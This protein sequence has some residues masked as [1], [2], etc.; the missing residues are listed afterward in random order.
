MEGSQIGSYQIERKLGAGGMGV[1]YIGID[2]RLGR[3]AAIK[4]L[5]PELSG[6]REIVERFFNE[7]KAAANINHPGIVEIYDVGWHSDGSAYFAMKWLDGDSLARRIRESGP[8][9][10]QLATT[11]ARQ[12][13]SALAAAH[14]AGIV[15]RDLKP[16]NIVLVRDDEVTIGERATVLDFGIAK[17]F[18]EQSASQ[19]TRTGSLL[20]TPAYMSPEQCRGA[21]EVDLRTDVYAL[22]CILFEML[23]GRPPHIGAGTGEVLGM[24]QF[25][26]ISKPSQFRKDLPRPLEALV[27]RALA[28]KP[29]ERFQHMTELMQALQPFA[30]Q[31]GRAPERPARP[32]EP[33]PRVVSPHAATQST[34]A[35]GHGEVAK[36]PSP[37]RKSRGL[38]LGLGGALVLGTVITIAAV[39]SSS[40]KSAKQDI[41]APPADAAVAIAFDAAPVPAP[42]PESSKL[43]AMLD[44]ATAVLNQRQW[45]KAAALAG[46]ALTI[47]PASARAK[48]ILT[49]ANRELVAESMFEAFARAA[50]ANDL[51]TLADRYAAIDDTSVYKA[52][53]KPTY[54]AAMDRYLKVARTKA[55][56]LAKT[57][58][59]GELA[60]FVIQAAKLF[61]ETEAPLAAIKCKGATG[62]GLVDPIGKSE[63]ELFIDGDVS[64]QTVRR[65]TRPLRGC[66][67]CLSEEPADDLARGDV[68]LSRTVAGD[69]GTAVLQSPRS[70]RP[71]TDAEVLQV[72]G[73]RSRAARGVERSERDREAAL[74]RRHTELAQARRLGRCLVEQ[75]DRIAVVRAHLGLDHRDR[76]SR[77]DGLLVL[78]RD[79]EPR[80]PR[81]D[82][83]TQVLDVPRPQLR[84]QRD[85]RRPVVDRVDL[86][87]QRARRREH[88]TGE[89]RDRAGAIF[90]EP[91]TRRHHGRH[92]MLGEERANRVFHQLDPDDV[93]T[94]TGE[95]REVLGLA[96]QRDQHAAG[97]PRCVTGQKLVGCAFVKSDAAFA[98]ALF[99]E[100]TFHVVKLP[101]SRPR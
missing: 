23:T 70:R 15:H 100:R 33:P 18:G 63:D 56:M 77:H 88:V 49:Q 101:R 38:W 68:R 95:K 29:E 86:A 97:K 61:P 46:D 94:A 99:P 74:G 80:A 98:P 5:L 93:V 6:N 40:G 64:E 75:H 78:D 19:K 83:R 84:R 43:A 73:H 11:I 42:P 25:V 47:D 9:P 8:M 51:P 48:E 22:G 17:L 36:P 66:A 67:A 69:E 87:D 32:T 96:A 76:R 55:G 30:A 28:R 79:E 34:L 45:Q 85:E 57:G 16:D 39:A 92:A 52:M 72:K 37:P 50:K 59:C 13:A 89:D 53:A 58:K 62:G 14:A 24:H 44:Q 26:D 71:R 54:L 81:R 60:D 91:I 90:D 20:G 82:Q 7:A 4:Q 27:M 41:P 12:V 10:I 31:G 35:T 2:L 3:R 1:V 65:G 21:G